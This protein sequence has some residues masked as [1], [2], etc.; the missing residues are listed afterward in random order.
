MKTLVLLFAIA[1]CGLWSTSSYAQCG[2]GQKPVQIQCGNT[3]TISYTVQTSGGTFSGS[4]DATTSPIV[5]CVGSGDAATSMI[6]TSQ[7]SIVLSSGS[8]SGIANDC[9]GTQFTANGAGWNA[10]STNIVLDIN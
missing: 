3:C 4:I 7:T 8:Q 2:L 5:H 1:G 10:T 6:A 9:V